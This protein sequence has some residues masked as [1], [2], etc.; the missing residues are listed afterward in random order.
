MKPAVRLLVCL[1]VLM[2]GCT[3]TADS[4]TTTSGA[5]APT[6]AAATTTASASTT[7]SM[8]ASSVTTGTTAATTTT[9][10]ATPSV[11]V[12]EGFSLLGGEDAGFLM[13]LPE[14]F[15]ALDLS[16]DDVSSLLDNSP[17]DADTRAA[18]QA[19]IEAGS[20]TFWAFDFSNAEGTFVPNVNAQILPGSG[21]DDIDVYLQVLPQQ[22]ASLGATMLSLDQVEYDFGPA[23]AAVVQI[24][25]GDGTHSTAFQLLAPVDDLVYTIT[26]SYLGPTDQQISEATTALSTFRPLR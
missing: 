20:F 3:R 11:E 7:T 6:D 5:T 13:A 21:L 8:P 14:G 23:L 9:T 1:L 16:S 15:V 24:P 19:A 17:L 10:P 22:Y 18:A 26:I 2:A 12:P 4:S 25:I